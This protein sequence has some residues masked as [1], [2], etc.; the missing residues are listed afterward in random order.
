M[1]LWIRLL[2]AFVSLWVI[3]TLVFVGLR[4]TGDP[5]LAV[6]NPDDLTKEMIEGFRKM[7][8]FEGTIWDQYV[9]YVTNVAHGHF[10][11]SILNGQDALDAVFERLPATLSLVGFSALVM[12]LIGIPVGTLAATRAGSK[13]DSFVMTGSTLGFAMPNFFFGLLLMLIFAVMLRMLPSGGS[14]SWQHFIMPVITIGVA[15]AAIFT[16]FVRS[17]VLDALRLQCVTAARARGF[18]EFEIYLR[19]VFPNSLI[20]VVTMLPLLIGAMV[21]ASAVVESVFAWPGIG[22][23]LVESVAQRNLAIVQVIIMFVAIVMIATN[24]TVDLLYGWLDPRT[25][26]AAAH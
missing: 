24:L 15:K 20:P 22:R 4:L 10:G 3:V 13:L 7:W 16:R 2:R 8:G 23:L 11:K 17:A 25:R 21:S 19:H 12:V 18:S 6:L 14:G 9:I 1:K 26:R 5:V